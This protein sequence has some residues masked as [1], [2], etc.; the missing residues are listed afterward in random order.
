[1][2]H[3][4]VDSIHTTSPPVQ[5]DFT[6]TSCSVKVPV[7]TTAR[8][9]SSIGEVPVPYGVT[10]IRRSA[11]SSLVSHTEQGTITFTNLLQGHKTVV[12]V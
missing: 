6:L 7:A 1:M 9:S 11:T 3:T 10:S 5:Q 4:M 12:L 2:Y 8:N